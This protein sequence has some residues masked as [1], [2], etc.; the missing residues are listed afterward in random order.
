MYPGET[1][2]AKHDCN[3]RCTIVAV[4]DNEF[5]EAQL[6]TI[7]RK[8]DQ[9]LLPWEAQTVA[10]TRRAFVE[11]EKAVLAKLRAVMV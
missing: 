6:E 4:V 3:E 1:G 7:W 2:M 10:A 5:S 8:F 11:Q 9:S